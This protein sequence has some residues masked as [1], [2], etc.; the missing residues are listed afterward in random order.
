MSAMEDRNQKQTARSCGSDASDCSASYFAGIG[1]QCGAYSESECGCPDVDWTPTE[2]YKLRSII[3]E[4]EIRHAAMMMHTQTIV[5]E[6]NELRRT[7]EG[8]QLAFDLRWKADRRAIK[9][10]QAAHPGNDLTWP[11]HA[12]MVVWLMEQISPDNANVDAPA[13]E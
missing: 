4:M 12:D 9:R 3:E 5:D 8:L 6:A 2:V 10:W 13:H 7:N 11:D 1:C